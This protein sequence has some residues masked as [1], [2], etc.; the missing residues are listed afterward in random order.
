[1]SPDLE[2]SL[3]ALSNSSKG[4][5]H[6]VDMVER[7]DFS[8]PVERAEVVRWIASEKRRRHRAYLRT[9]EGSAIR[10]ADAAGRAVWI[11]MLALAVSALALWQSWK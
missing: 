1:M 3:T 7:G 10:Q 6:I 9:P 2:K 8:D 11:S 4:L 5:P